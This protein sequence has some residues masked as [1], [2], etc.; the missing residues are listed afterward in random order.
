M[1]KTKGA[2]RFVA[3]EQEDDT[4]LFGPMPPPPH[5]FTFACKAPP[6]GYKYCWLTQEDVVHYLLSSIGLFSPVAALPIGT[7]GIIDADVL[8]IDYH[9]PASFSLSAILRSLRDQ[10][11][12]VV[13]DKNG[14]LIGEISPFTLTCCDEAV[15]GSLLVRKMARYM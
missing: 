4:T 13:I 2:I 9:S 5:A 6:S 15:A 10:T 11:F 8:A 12:V 7:L 3:K 14:A 1:S